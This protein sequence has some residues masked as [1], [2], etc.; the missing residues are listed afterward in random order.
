LWG[1]VNFYCQIKLV[2]G[3]GKKEEIKKN[4]WGAVGFWEVFNLLFQL[5]YLFFNLLPFL[6]G[7]LIN[8][9]S[10]GRVFTI[11]HCDLVPYGLRARV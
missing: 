1:K 2:N 10:A 6:P 8:H 9:S 4:R 11:L 7:L 5:A 3:L